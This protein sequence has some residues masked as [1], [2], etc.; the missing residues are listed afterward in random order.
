MV[1]LY[2]PLED[3]THKLQVEEGIYDTACSPNF[4]S[5]VC[6]LPIFPTLRLRGVC[7]GSNIDTDY[8]LKYL[9]GS[10]VYMGVRGSQVKCFEVQFSPQVRFV[11]T[12]GQEGWWL[13]VNLASTTAYT[14]SGGSSFALGNRSW[15][16]RNDT[17]KCESQVTIIKERTIFTG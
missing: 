10:V 14:S 16:I 4:G 12:L 15:V 6:H 8:K 1:I 7:K 5:C 17:P 9:N 11:S 3:T 13:T 2:S